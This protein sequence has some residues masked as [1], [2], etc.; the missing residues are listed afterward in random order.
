VLKDDLHVNGGTDEPG[1]NRARGIFLARQAVGVAPGDAEVL[2]TAAFEPAYYGEDINTA[3]G[4]VD[5]ALEL[6]PS[7]ARGWQRS[8]W[9]RLWAGH[10]DIAIEHFETP[11]RL[12]RREPRANPFMGIGVAHLC[13]R[14][15]EEARATLLQSLQKKRNWVP[16][17]RFLASC[18]AQMGRLDDAREAVK[19]LRTLTN[20]VVP[21]PRIGGTLSSAGSTCRVCA[22]RLAR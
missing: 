13:A 5:R 4:L 21:T 11:L 6:N 17:Y 3:I 12:N 14:R 7:F 18:Y 1:A 9:L 19:R 20:V 8:G 15:F 16:T 10:P 2:A 22:R